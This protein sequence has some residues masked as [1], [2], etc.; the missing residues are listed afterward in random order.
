MGII[1]KVILLGDSCVGKTSLL[2]RYVDNTFGDYIPQTIGADF[3]FKDIDLNNIINKI[4]I[5]D[6]AKKDLKKT[7]FKIYFWEIEGMHNHLF[8]LDYYF[9][10]A[11]GAMVVFNVNNRETFNKLDFWIS[12]MKDLCGEIPFIIVGNKIDL[13]NKRVISTDEI[14]NKA[15]E[16]GVS[17]F[18]T[19]A[20]L[21]KNVSVAFQ[22]LSIQILNNLKFNFNDSKIILK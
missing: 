18:E 20:R 9:L 15:N 22:D 13:E 5:K 19:S 3:L 16:Y 2:N 12:K 6:S 17:F 4:D 8:V 21:N 10:H 14:E 1:S 11:D 7:N